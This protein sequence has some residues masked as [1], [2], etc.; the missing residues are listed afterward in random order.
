MITFSI[1]TWSCPGCGYSQDFEP[2]QELFDKHINEDPNIPVNNLEQGM[3]PNCALQGKEV[4]LLA[5]EDENRC[6]RI[7]CSEVGD[8]IMD[9]GGKVR[10]AKKAEVK[11]RADFK[12]HLHDTAE[13]RVWNETPWE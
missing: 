9:E 1:K 12:T 5:V 2:T 11:T 7:T 4:E 8:E 3:C 13:A 10:P 6:T